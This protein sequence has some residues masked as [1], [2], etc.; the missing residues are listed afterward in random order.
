MV[1]NNIYVNVRALVLYC[2]FIFHPS[3]FR[4]PERAG[5][6]SVADLLVSDQEQ[7][8]VVLPG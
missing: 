4:L 7:A 1:F 8:A 2:V 6:Q 5:E 3:C